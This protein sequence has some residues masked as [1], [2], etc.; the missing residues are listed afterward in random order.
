MLVGHLL[1]QYQIALRPAVGQMR[2]AEIAWMAVQ[3]FEVIKEE[4]QPRCNARGG[5]TLRGHRSWQPWDFAQLAAG[6]LSPFQQL[7]NSDL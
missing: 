3:A 6:L 5:A 4:Q 7:F 1:Q 2:T